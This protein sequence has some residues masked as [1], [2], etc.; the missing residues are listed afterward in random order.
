MDAKKMLTFLIAALVLI[1][2]VHTSF[3]AESKVQTFKTL[4][5]AQDAQ[6]QYLRE[7]NERTKK[8]GVDIGQALK[9]VKDDKLYKNDEKLP[10]VN[11]KMEALNEI[12]GR[13]TGS[14]KLNLVLEYIRLARDENEIKVGRP[15]LLFSAYDTGNVVATKLNGGTIYLVRK[16]IVAHRKDC[17]KLFTY[18][19]ELFI[20]ENS[21]LDI[22]M[23]DYDKMKQEKFAAKD[24]KTISDIP[25]IKVEKGS[26][27][28]Q[29]AELVLASGNNSKVKAGKT[30]PL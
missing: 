28:F 18:K 4:K 7:Q 3:A 30:N 12:F 16:F 15:T 23:A 25:K 8:Y 2:N 20:K 19:L 21:S 6:E 1:F 27:L 26:R 5:E 11:K 10:P 9:I 29:I 13:M 17:N 24:V 14:D 22:Y